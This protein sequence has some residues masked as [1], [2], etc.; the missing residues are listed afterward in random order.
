MRARRKGTRYCSARC[1]VAAHRA[2]VREHPAGFLARQTMRRFTRANDP[3]GGHAPRAVTW[4][5]VHCDAGFERET[6]WGAYVARLRVPGGAWEDLAVGRGRLP[7]GLPGPTPAEGIAAIAALRWIEAAMD[8]GV[9][10]ATCPVV[11]CIDSAPVAAKVRSGNS[12]GES[13]EIWTALAAAGA[14]LRTN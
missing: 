13:A 6:A 4:L 8:A 2:A 12:Q 10:D 14:R 11:L 3:D 1:R 9:V 7:D 5:E